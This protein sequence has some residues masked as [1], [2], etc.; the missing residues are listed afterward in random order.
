MNT[1]V[2]IW[3]P[4]LKLLCSRGQGHSWPRFKFHHSC[5]VALWPWASGLTFLDLR[6]HMIKWDSNCKTLSV[7]LGPSKKLV[8]YCCW[9]TYHNDSSESCTCAMHHFTCSVE[10]FPSWHIC[11]ES[12]LLALGLFWLPFRIGNN[13]W[14]C[15]T[16]ALTHRVYLRR[17][18]LWIPLTLASSWHMIRIHLFTGTYVLLCHF[19]C[20]SLS[21]PTNKKGY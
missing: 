8:I 5:L 4:W 9:K 13:G 21:L 6:F 18:C 16:K 11:Q 19:T 1:I 17:S 2:N 7:S 3:P 20:S 14:S 12:G 15:P 10:A